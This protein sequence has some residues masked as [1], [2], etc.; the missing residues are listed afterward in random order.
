M[1]KVTRKIWGGIVTYEDADTPSDT[2]RSSLTGTGVP[3]FLKRFTSA[4]SD[5]S[6]SCASSIV[7]SN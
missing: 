3:S 6:K 4:T 5:I 2:G 7:G 1:I